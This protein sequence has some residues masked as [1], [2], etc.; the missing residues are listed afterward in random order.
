M[1][2]D[3]AYTLATGYVA[4]S[5]LL[6]GFYLRISAIKIGFIRALSWASY[7]KYA[8]QAMGRIELLGRVWSP[9]TC[10]L[11]T[12]K[13]FI[14]SHSALNVVKGIQSFIHSKLG[15]D[16]FESRGWERQRSWRVSTKMR[17]TIQLHWYKTSA[18]G[19]SWIK[20]IR[21]TLMPL[22]I[23]HTWQM[24]TWISRPVSLWSCSQHQ[25]HVCRPNQ[26]CTDRKLYHRGPGHAGLLWIHN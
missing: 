10:T 14:T 18:I 13:I 12:G 20:E 17:T 23:L 16:L 4:A 9:S 11:T 5:I 21:R 26:W 2:Q 25:V 8:M 6:S 7:T 19:N 24:S 1:M 15:D 3:M 22:E